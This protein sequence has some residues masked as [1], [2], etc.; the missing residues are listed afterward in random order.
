MTKTLVYVPIL[1]GSADLGSVAPEAEKRG[2]KMLGEE[3]W[4]KHKETISKFWDSISDYLNS[5]DVSGFKLYQDSLVSAGEPVVQ[6]IETIAK[7]GSKNYKI[8][9]ELIKKGAGLVKTEDLSLVQKEVEQIKSI[10]QKS[11]KFGKLAAALK[12]KMSKKQLLEDRDSF[13]AGQIGETL[14]EGETGIL[15]IGGFHNVIPKLSTRITVKQVKEKEKVERY[16]KIFFLKSKK[17]EADQLAVYLAS[18][19]IALA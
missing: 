10:V 17:V 6:M 2:I 16:Q 15:F 7:S 14:K 9:S 1:H 18:P 19:V 11:S 8:L 12:Y 5:L 13:I 3:G 4:K